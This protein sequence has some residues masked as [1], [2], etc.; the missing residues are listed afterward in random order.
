[1]N[2]SFNK[3]LAHDHATQLRVV[4]NTQGWLQ[5]P[6]SVVRVVV[7]V[8]KHQGQKA[9]LWENVLSRDSVLVQLAFKTCNREN[10]T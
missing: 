2:N 7:V 10:A 6:V 1:M 8:Q 9:E 5:D 3:L 4:S